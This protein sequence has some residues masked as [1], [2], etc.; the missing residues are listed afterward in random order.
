MRVRA[1]VISVTVVATFLLARWALSQQSDP[2]TTFMRAK[3]WQANKLFEGVMTEDFDA[4]AR[5]C[6]Q[7][8]LLSH[9]AAWNVIQTPTYRRYSEEF[10]RLTDDTAQAAKDKNLDAATL[11]Y[12]EMTIKCAKCHTYSRRTRK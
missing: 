11:G 10:R 3:L 1:A 8:N 6:E 9:E 4:I 7:L 5:H 12:I 2:A